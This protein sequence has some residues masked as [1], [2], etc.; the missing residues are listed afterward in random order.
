MFRNQSFW[1][2]LRSRAIIAIK[3]IIEDFLYT[4]DSASYRITQAIL[5]HKIIRTKADSKFLII[6]NSQIKKWS[7]NLKIL[8]NQ[9]NFFPD[10]DFFLGLLN[11]SG[12]YHTLL[13]ME[14]I[15]V[16]IV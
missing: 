9:H 11:N 2:E 7:H 8:L 1:L 15:F 5:T 12:L 4:H 3:Q 6:S 16:T 13:S 10:L 14:L